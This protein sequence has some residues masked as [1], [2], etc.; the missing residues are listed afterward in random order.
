VNSGG[1]AAL[2]GGRWNPRGTETIYAAASR[3]L[4]VLEIMVHYSV[5]PRD[6]VL[7]E[8]EIP[9]E[10]PID[11]LISNDLPRG[12]NTPAPARATQEIGRRWIR[13]AATAVL[14]VPSAIVPTESI[15]LL[16]PKHKDFRLLKFASPVP[17]RFDGRLKK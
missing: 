7:T 11:R 8:I 6:F 17:F 16:N 15:Y 4:A 3:S 1:G 12:W 10:V 2:H 13:S 5:L 9:P 14:E